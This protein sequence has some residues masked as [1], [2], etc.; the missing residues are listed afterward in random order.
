M[1]NKEESQFMSVTQTCRDINELKPNARLAIQLLFQEC[2]KAGIKD[3]FV[4]ETYRSQARQ[5]YLYE[6][7]RTRPGNQVTWTLN[8][9]HT[10]RLAW[11]IATAPPKNLY[12]TPTLQKVGAIAKKLGIE[13]GGYWKAPNY[14]APHFQVSANW[15]AP[16]GYKL[17]G[18]VGVP[19]SSKERITFKPYNNGN[20]ELTVSQY[21][22]LKQL[23][24]TL[25][26]ENK[27]L[28]TELE[29]KLNKPAPRDVSVS[30]KEGWKWL[31]D[32]GISNGANPQDYVSREQFG[33]M[34]KRYYDK[35]NK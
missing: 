16:S 1:R 8:S 7:G 10:P 19:T 29:L 4:T 32:S 14:D 25:Q 9:N 23:I 26:N 18:V 11:D 28:K 13:W 31:T 21:N 3:I 12:D 5:N 6:Q 34:L 15:K 24:T 17:E 30:H 22:E 33:T 20:E 2:F 35:F 27:Q